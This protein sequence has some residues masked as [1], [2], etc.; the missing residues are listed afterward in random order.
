MVVL[1]KCDPGKFSSQ[2][3]D[4][5]IRSTLFGMLHLLMERLTLLDLPSVLD[6]VLEQFLC[7]L[8]FPMGIINAS[9]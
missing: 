7:H 5:T 4:L 9:I 3:Y 2:K 1:L 8:G 6:P